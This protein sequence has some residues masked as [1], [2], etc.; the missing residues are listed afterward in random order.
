MKVGHSLANVIETYLLLQAINQ[1]IWRMGG[2]E[3]IS[4]VPNDT[5]YTRWSCHIG[6]TNPVQIVSTPSAPSNGDPITVFG[7]AG[8][9]DPLDGWQCYS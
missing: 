5:A 4:Q 9:A 8:H 7:R 1:Y 2:T 6:L 3:Y